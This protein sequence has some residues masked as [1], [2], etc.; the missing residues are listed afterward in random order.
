M[1]LQCFEK[2]KGKFLN[3]CKYSKQRIMHSP[4]YLLTQRVKLFLKDGKDLNMSLEE[5]DKLCKFLSWN[6]IGVFNDSFVHLYNFRNY[7]VLIDQVKKL[8]FVYTREGKKLYFK[9]GMSCKDV[10]RMYRSLEEEQDLRSPH[11]YFFDGLELSEKSI[12][13]DIGVAEGNFGLK[14]VDQIK[15]LYLFE[16]DAGWIEALEATF[17]PWKN[18]VHILN[19]FVSDIT[20]LD[21]VRLEDFFRDKSV[22][23]VLKL[24]VEGAE[25]SV[26]DGASFFLKQGVITDLLVCTYHK[27][28]DPETLSAKLEGFNYKINFTKGYM[29]FLTEGYQA[30][31]PYDFRK[32]LLH[33]KYALPFSE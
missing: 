11:Y 8:P 31:P 7:N 12:V 1:S 27:K 24:D 30:P 3:L 29:L 16:C 15:E 19:Y 13:A 23:N 9:R 20:S 14:I 5:A 33:A 22:P 10:V 2:L 21:T 18:K 26:L 6:L 25:A 17:E 4:R 28:R 32:G